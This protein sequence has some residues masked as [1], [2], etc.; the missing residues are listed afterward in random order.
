[1]SRWDV[2]TLYTCTS[3]CPLHLRVGFLKHSFNF[4]CSLR[5][6][7]EFL[8]SYTAVEIRHTVPLAKGQATGSRCY[9]IVSHVPF[10]AL[11]AVLCCA[12]FCSLRSSSSSRSSCSAEGQSEEKIAI[13]TIRAGRSHIKLTL[14]RSGAREEILLRPKRLH[15]EAVSGESPTTTK[16]TQRVA[17]A[18]TGRATASPVEFGL[19]PLQMFRRS[20]APSFERSDFGRGFVALLLDGGELRL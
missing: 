1:M 9:R 17:V 6:P 13:S 12:F 2:M 10:S 3:K 18:N 7:F 16:M 20:V 8:L 5:G 15:S 14:R 4:A 19:F 11:A